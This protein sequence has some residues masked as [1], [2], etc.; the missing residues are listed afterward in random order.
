MSRVLYPGTDNI[1]VETTGISHYGTEAAAD[2]VTNPSLLQEALKKLP[3]RW[4][5][6]NVQLALDVE[7]VSGYPSVPTVVASYV[8]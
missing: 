3:P 5:K 6:K 8:W 2:L 7:V 1:I 4:Q